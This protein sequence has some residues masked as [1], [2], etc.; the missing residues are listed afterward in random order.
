VN[1]HRDAGR[2]SP[3]A[4]DVAVE[5]HLEQD[6]TR[7]QHATDAYLSDPSQQ[8][9]QELLSALESLDQQTAA[10]DA[11]EGSVM[12]SAAYGF[13]TK[14]SVIGET[15]QNPI[16]EQL[17]G[18]VLRAQIALVKA[19]K[20]AVTDAGPSTLD[21]LRAANTELTSMRSPDDAHQSSEGT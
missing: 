15:S 11:Y 5:V 8:R 10:S 14:G 12:G 1:F 16:A 2:Q 6:I 9:R 17:S 7:V 13:S 21:A 3:E 20:S 18:S 4:Q 19:A